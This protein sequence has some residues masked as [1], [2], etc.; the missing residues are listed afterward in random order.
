MGVVL[1]TLF[2][3]EFP[4]HPELLVLLPVFLIT[5]LGEEIGWRGYA[6]PKLLAQR[7]ALVSSLVIGILWGMVHLALHLPGLMLSAN[8]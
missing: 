5:N 8:P 4:F 3:G 2:G 6:L 7:S 1:A